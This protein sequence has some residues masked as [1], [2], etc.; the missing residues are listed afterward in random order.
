M[1]FLD[2]YNNRL[3]ILNEDG[4][5]DKEIPCSLSNPFDVTCLDDTTVAVST[6]SGIE[7]ININSAKTERRIETSK[8]CCGITHHNGV[9]LLCELERGIQMKRLSDDRATTLVKQINLPYDS[10]ITACGDK[11]YQT[12]RNTSPF[13]CYTMKGEKLWEYR[14]VSVL[15]NPQGVTVDNNSN[16]Y[17]T[18]RTFNSVVV[19]EPDGRQGRQLISNDDGLTNRPE[20]ILTNL[21]TVCWLSTTMDRLSCIRCAKYFVNVGKTILIHILVVKTVSHFLK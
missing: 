19:I 17:V 7:I 5:L 21:K 16:V 11:I 13:T 18:S 20:Y 10:Y 6:Y 2:Y 4:T 9:L 8:Q 12:N 14:D 3:V 15:K 1:I